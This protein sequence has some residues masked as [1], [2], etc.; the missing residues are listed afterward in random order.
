MSD[1]ENKQLR[2][3]ASE[4]K[5][6]AYAGAY[7][8]HTRLFPQ[9]SSGNFNLSAN[10][11]TVQTFELPTKVYNLAKSYLRW[12]QGVTAGG[13]GSWKWHL[14]S[15][16]PIDRMTL[17]TRAGQTIA[18]IPNFR[19]YWKQSVNLG[20][21]VGEF[22][23][24][25]YA[26][27][28]QTLANSRL[29]GQC[30]FHNPSGALPSSAT[31]GETL[32]ARSVTQ[33]GAL[34]AVGDVWQKSYVGPVHVMVSTENADGYLTC[35]LPLE[36]IIQSIFCMDKDFYSV[37]ALQLE[38]TM[39]GYDK[40]IFEADT[41]VTAITNPISSPEALAITNFS[42]YLAI[43]QNEDLSKALIAKVM[44]DGVKLL[45]PYVTV[46]SYS[47]GVATAGSVQVKLNRGHGHQLLRILSCEMV[48]ADNL[49]LSHNFYNYNGALTS[50]Y[51]TQLDSQNLEQESLNAT[52]G[53]DYQVNHKFLK[54]TPIEDMVTWQ[55][56]APV[57]INDFCGLQD[58]KQAKEIDF[59][60]QNNALDLSSVEHTWNRVI[61]TKSA[62]AT[63][64]IVSI[65]GQKALMS[66]SQGIMVQ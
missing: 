51:R 33:A 42:L 27:L 7:Y 47:L 64:S 29:R 40:V 24:R 41:A 1:S 14:L 12:E 63:S 9:Q 28:S 8:N 23:N 5:I 66:S 19:A 43:E 15:A 49:N 65:V 58:L 25:P 2:N 44:S 50:I 34:S 26:G 13:A 3:P 38:V 53:T 62:T 59:M 61:E 31:A 39:S 18:D 30:R 37:E 57:H 10:S 55:T 21:P 60:A 48:T 6:G 36:Y 54:G 4:L 46:N 11:Q 17:R 22:V 56:W 16:P 45:I 32:N 52:L 35:Y 20:V